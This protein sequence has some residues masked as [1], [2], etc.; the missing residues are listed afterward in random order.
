MLL[1]RGAFLLLIGFLCVLFTPRLKLLLLSA[2]TLS[3][4]AVKKGLFRGVFMVCNVSLELV[5]VYLR[6]MHLLVIKTVGALT[7]HFGGVFV[8]VGRSGLFKGG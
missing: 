8:L 5:W 7:P 4:N 2:L 3:F 6:M 1:G